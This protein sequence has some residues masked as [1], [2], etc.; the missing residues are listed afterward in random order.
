L[1]GRHR[2]PPRLG[3]VPPLSSS[4]RP[5]Q[6]VALAPGL[7]EIVG[8][9]YLDRPYRTARPSSADQAVI[10][11]YP[12]LD[13]HAPSLRTAI[14]SCRHSAADDANPSGCHRSHT[15]VVITTRFSQY[16]FISV[17]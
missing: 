14:P 15:T 13:L 6:I 1:A 4:S 11:Q 3:R 12:T 10:S 2:L 8:L 5:G 17:H 7:L 9:F 16:Q